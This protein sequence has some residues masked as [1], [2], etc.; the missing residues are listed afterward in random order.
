MAYKNLNRE[1]N[2]AVEHTEGPVLI[3]AG[4]GSG[5]TATMTHRMAHLVEM[6]TDPHNILAVTFTNK[7]A[8]E[9]RERVQKLVDDTQGMWIMTFHALCLRMLRYS[10]DKIGYKSGFTVYDETDK[11]S[12]I[13]KV[14]KELEVDEKQY[15][16]AAAIG[17]I[18][19]AKENEEG[20]EQMLDIAL[21]R[22]Y[23]KYQELLM[24]NNAMDFDDLLWN[25]V[26]LLEQSPEAL[27]YYSNRFKY[28]MVDEY[29]DTNYLQYKL[30]RMLASRHGNLCVVGD[31]DQCIYQWRG[32]DIRNILD[33]EHD[34]KNVYTIRLEQNYRSDANILNLANS[35]IKNNAS[36]KEKALWT[37]H[38]DG[39]KITYK[40]LENE[41]QEA[42]YIGSEIE[43]WRDKGYKYSDMAVLYRKNAQSRP[44]EEKFSFRGIPYRVLAGLRF[45]DRKE[46]KDVMAYLRLIENP[47]DDVSML[48]IINEPKRGIGAKTLSAIE[49]Y[50]RSYNYSLFQALCQEELQAVLGN[51]SRDAIKQLIEMIEDIRAEQENL[52]ISAIYDNVLRRSG[53]LAALEAA[54]TVEADGRI[55]NIMEFKSVIGEF[56]KGVDDGSLE[57]FMDEI[58]EE[59]DAI[60]GGSAGT[61]EPTILGTFLERI[62]L[63]SDIDNH[64]ADEDAVVLMTLHSAKGLEFPIVFIPGMETTVFPGAMAFESDAKMEEE[65]RLCYVGI[66][67]AMK[68]LYLTGAQMRT[69]YGKTDFQNESIFLDEMDKQYL[70]GD[71]T[72]KERKAKSGGT[73]GEGGYLGDRFWGSGLNGNF[74][75]YSGAPADKP[76]GVKLT[77]A[78]YSDSLVRSTAETKQK[79]VEDFQIGDTLRHPK[80]GEG[81][82]IEQDAKTMTI[83]FDSVGQKKLGKGFVKMEKVDK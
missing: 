7:A 73:F 52:T 65:R 80:F 20:P 39:E 33:F 22:V 69:L 58:R 3:L 35:V 15:P 29:Q 19:K 81:M 60:L 70:D 16:V 24:A 82:L 6:G 10:A 17:A 40:R 1:Q 77:H 56:E 21:R 41:K 45:Y 55:E 75:G 72:M 37:E 54:N 74:D 76:F 59:R 66:T 78:N 71:D 31:D 57:D 47:N 49:G 38:P 42:W 63:M 26:K 25:G 9:M 5:K 30:I 51:K 36:R 43:A 46:I 53:Y 48:R 11:K 32:A 62:T 13:K 64:N 8:N 79:I 14:Y 23:A 28:I 12:L 34:F 50:A 18:S 61:S 67:R 44:F 68:K 2:K 4:A 83:M 27:E